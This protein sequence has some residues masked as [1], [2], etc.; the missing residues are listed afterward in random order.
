MQLSRKLFQIWDMELSKKLNQLKDKRGVSER[1]I[2]RSLKEL[3]PEIKVSPTTV[4]R[5]LIGDGIPDLEQAVALAEYFG[6]PLTYLAYDDA[7]TAPGELPDDEATVLK[8]YRNLRSLGAIDEALATHGMAMA[9]KG[10]PGGSQPRPH[11][12]V[13]ITA[14]TPDDRVPVPEGYDPTYRHPLR[15]KE[16]FEGVRSRPVEP[17]AAEAGGRAPKEARPAPRRRKP[18]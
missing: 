6:V 18:G 1:Q 11:T 7:T 8:V 15:P 4:N 2:A 5:W 14:E 3:A 9:A 10:L 12:E 17:D 16:P 13:R